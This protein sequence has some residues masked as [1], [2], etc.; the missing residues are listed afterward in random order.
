MILFLFDY[1]IAKVKQAFLGPLVGNH[2]HHTFAIGNA[3]ATTLTIG[4][5]VEAPALVE[6]SD[7]KVQPLECHQNGIVTV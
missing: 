5:V 2:D 1:I 4:N 7:G 6:Q 3:M